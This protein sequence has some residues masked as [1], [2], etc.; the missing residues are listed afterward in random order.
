[1]LNLKTEPLTLLARGSSDLVATSPEQVCIAH[2]S[3]GGKGLCPVVVEYPGI[4][5]MEEERV[6]ACFGIAEKARQNI[7]SEI[8]VRFR[9]TWHR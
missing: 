4:G 9:G 2:T 3:R 6:M 7:G 8:W 1:V 5:F